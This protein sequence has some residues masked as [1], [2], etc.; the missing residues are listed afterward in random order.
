MKKTLKIA[1]RDLVAHV[2]RSGDLSF[3][4][5]AS[6]RPVDAIRIHQKI[7]QSRPENYSAEVT[8]SHLI[9]T[10]LCQLTIS[11][12]VDGIYRDAD[13][14]LIEEIKTTTRSL[15][16]FE[17]RADP[18]HWGQVKA[19]AY[20]VAL[21]QELSALDAQL[22]YYQVDTAEIRSFKKHFRLSELETFFQDLV[23]NYLQWATTVVNWEIL[24]DESIARLE[25]P[26]GEYRPGQREMAIG[27]YRTIKHNGQQLIQAATGIGKTMA[28]LFPAVKALGEDLTSKIFFLTARTT[29]RFAAEYALDELRSAGLK[30]KSLTI[31][32]KDKTCFNPESACSP[33]ECEFARGHYDRVNG[34]L[35]DI[36]DQQAFT[37][38]AVEQTARDHRVCPFELALELSLWADCVI[39]D[40]NYAF[41][42]RVYLRRFFLEEN[43]DYTFLI[44]EAHNLVDRSR[45]MFSAAF[46]K[47]PLL[48]VR[49]ALRHDQPHIFKSL[50]K[51]NAWMVKARK[52]CDA[53]GPTLHEKEPPED[54]F[55]LLRGFL[56]ITERWLARNFKTP[57]RDR[58]LDLF[59][60]MSGFIRVAEHYDDSYVTCFEKIKKDVKLK[61]FCID[62]S[63]QLGSALKRS[64]AAVFFSATMS[65]MGY[66]KNI[67]GCD[68]NAAGLI[69]PS[70]FPV[71]NLKLFVYDRIST[72][73]RQRASTKQQVAQAIASLIR[74]KTGNYLIFFPSYEYMMMV[75]NAF[76]TETPDGEVIVQAPGMGETEREEFLGRFGQENSRSLIGFA[77]MGGIFGEGIDLVGD[78][79]C[80]AV[81]VGV[82]LP[83]ISQENELIRDYFATHHNA[84]FEYA[85]QYPGINRVLQAAGR[86]IRTE[87]DRGVVL[88]IDQRYGTHRYRSLLPAEWHPVKMHNEQQLTEALQKFWHR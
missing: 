27:V 47:Q 31:T 84:G 54:L 64:K 46:H 14:A 82:G 4:F 11:G 55:P 79:L 21:D 77:V 88:L 35:N 85:Y 19:Y 7:Q 58:L 38:P 81:V 63:I 52:K 71:E 44:D 25:F 50:G 10:D 69:L 76:Q 83:G 43:G 34:A 3:E 26:F 32:A 67:L 24:R 40:Y 36:F 73:Y 22:T 62:P 49:R 37:R 75:L 70:P 23:D 16:D 29:G 48:D 20:M 42:P 59:F 13:G 66:F 1:V 57:Y 56:R 17:D 28:A 74:Q 45:E 51:I 12:R 60:A 6:T 86:V 72:L 39:C 65:P 5:L 80:G 41:D 18:I 61:L 15:D 9:E 87:S 33:E 30:L 53:S 78:R 68:E 2:L 8:V